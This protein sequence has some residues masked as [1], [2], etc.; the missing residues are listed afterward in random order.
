[1][2][3]QK[4]ILA[5]S[6]RNKL[7]FL[8]P[9]SHRPKL[10]NVRTGRSKIPITFNRNSSRKNPKITVTTVKKLDIFKNSKMPAISVSRYSDLDGD[11]TKEVGLRFRRSSNQLMLFII[12]CYEAFMKFSKLTD[13]L[14]SHFGSNAYYYR[15]LIICRH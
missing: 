13:L 4:G 7:N 15:G 9:L 3:I 8:S 2:D 10:T 1:M 11:Y 14:F 5:N 12:S 6:L